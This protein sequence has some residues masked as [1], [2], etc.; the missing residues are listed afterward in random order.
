MQKEH[1]IY[2]GT[3]KVNIVKNESLMGKMTVDH[4]TKFIKEKYVQDKVMV[5]WLMAAPSGFPFYHTLI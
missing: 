1:I 3:V 4:I 5:L 2:S